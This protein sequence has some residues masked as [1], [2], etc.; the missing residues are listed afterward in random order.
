MLTSRIFYFIFIQI[1]NQP[2]FLGV[3]CQDFPADFFCHYHTG[4]EEERVEDQLEKVAAS[5]D[6][7]IEAGRGAG[8]PYENLPP[9]IKEH[10]HYHLWQ[11]CV[12]GGASDSARGEI[13]GF[14]AP[15][16]GM[17]FVDLGCCLNFMLAGYK[18]WPSLYYGVDISA[19]TIDLLRSFARKNSLVAGDFLC[20][21]MHNTPYPD[22]FF[23][24]GAC[25][26]SLEYF[27][28]DFVRQSLLEFHR[29]MRAGGRFVLDIPNVGSG[30]AQVAAL[31]EEYLGRPDKF[32]LNPGEFESLLGDFFAVRKKEACGAMIQY[33]LTVKKTGALYV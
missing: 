8:N 14:L 6:R 29:I 33:F 9:H 17:R 11:K 22:D 31:V 32:D 23:D 3:I 27:E 28:R 19:R 4:R 20:A 26:G 12:Q 7:A 1:E 25:V 5:Y 15:E 13:R 21:S 18:D 10:P 2:G 16:R 24:I 30:E